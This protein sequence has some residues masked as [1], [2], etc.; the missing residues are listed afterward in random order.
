MP[1]KKLP[2]IRVKL[3]RIRLNFRGPSDKWITPQSLDTKKQR[4]IMK[5]R[6]KKEEEV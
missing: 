2:I 5:R 1:P 3:P 4:A 6:L